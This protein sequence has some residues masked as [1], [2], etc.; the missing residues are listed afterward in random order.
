MKCIK[1]PDGKITRIN[2]IIAD[3]LVSDGK[4]VYVPKKEWKLYRAKTEIVTDTTESPK[5]NKK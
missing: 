2:D 3:Q 1:Y 5:K 4:S